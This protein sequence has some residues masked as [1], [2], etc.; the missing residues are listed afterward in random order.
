MQQ[1]INYSDNKIRKIIERIYSFDNQEELQIFFP[2]NINYFEQDIRYLKK[3]NKTNPELINSLSKYKGTEYK[4]INNVLIRKQFPLIY[5]SPSHNPDDTRYLFPDDVYKVKQ[6]KE[7][8]IL[9]C[10]NNIDKIILNN[11]TLDDTILFRGLIIP[12]RRKIDKNENLF[13]Q[14]STNFIY[15][16]INYKKN[17]VIKFDNF[18]S[19]TFNLNIALDFTY[20]PIDSAGK[21]IKKAQNNNETILLIIRIK[22]EHEIPSVFC[23]NIFFNNINNKSFIREWK[24]K[25]YDEF[26][27]LL[28]RNTEFKITNIKVIHNKVKKGLSISNVYDKLK[29]DNYI[30]LVFLESLPFQRPEPFEPKKKY[31]Y[32]C[33]T[34]DN[35][36]Y[37]K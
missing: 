17:N 27:V 34:T 35:V 14:L 33:V 19:T 15:N 20:I 24:Y 29:T 21:L 31:K 16:N 37:R 8:G 32:V 7:K 30:K 13:A 3:I 2:Q 12:K 25:I 10:I 26:E 36:N 1:I 4:L 11:K 23:S 28:S 22:K 9:D 5:L 6:K 18:L